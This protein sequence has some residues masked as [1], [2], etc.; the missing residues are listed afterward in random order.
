[1][2]K[3]AKTV[4]SQAAPGDEN[5][6]AEAATKQEIMESVEEFLEDPIPMAKKAVEPKIPEWEI[7][8]RVYY[9]KGRKRP[10]SYMIKSAGIYYFD[11]EAGYE[12][13]MKYCEN[14]KTS[15]VDE[16]KGD[17]RLAHVIFRNGALHVPREKQTLQ[18]L[19]SLY[20][21][22][23]N[24]VY[25]EYQPVQEA[26]DQMYFLELEVDA[27][28]AARDMDIDMAE[29]IMRVESGSKVSTL[30]SKELKRDLLIFAKRNP[31]LFLE[32]AADENVQLRNFGIKAVENGIL[33]LSTDQR[34]FMWA[35]NDRKLMNIPFEEHPYSALASWFK[36]DEGMEVYLSIEKRLK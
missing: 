25:S 28:L 35:S 31:A 16:M 6:V 29:A 30:S 36:T 17:Q 32:L 18:R 22:G 5:I 27:L 12:R 15:F 20:H 3:K 11:E 23:K 14:Q 1:M 19:L 26:E 9:L 4:S 33:K 7:K 13:E 8:D 34:H 2:A 21:P 24:Q 10:L